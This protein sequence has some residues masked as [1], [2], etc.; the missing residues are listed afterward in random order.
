MKEL[1]F[2]EIW[3]NKQLIGEIK[4][5]N[6]SKIIAIGEKLRRY[7]ENSMKKLNV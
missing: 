2:L 5:K 3:I 4:Y 7:C 6:Q 1:K